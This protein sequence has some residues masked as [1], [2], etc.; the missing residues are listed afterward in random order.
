MLGGEVN[1]SLVTLLDELDPRGIVHALGHFRH[2]II[3]IRAGNDG[4]L[5]MKKNLLTL[6]YMGNFSA[7]F[8]RK[9]LW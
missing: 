3:Q 9:S 6:L 4:G 1:P 8:Y 2:S 5:K 7:Y